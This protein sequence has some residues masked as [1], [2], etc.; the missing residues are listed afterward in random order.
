VIS[1]VDVC[2]NCGGLLIRPGGH[3]FPQWRH[4]RSGHPKCFVD[5]KL[6]QSEPQEHAAVVTNEH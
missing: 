4:K 2:K 6:V 1:I 3:S 5:G